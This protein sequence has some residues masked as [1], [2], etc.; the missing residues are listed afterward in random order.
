MDVEYVQEGPTSII[1]DNR[2][3]MALAKNPT[4]HSHNKD[5][6]VEYHLII[7]KLEKK[8]V[9]CLKYRPMEDMIA[10]ML[11]KPLANSRHQTLTK[12]TFDD[13]QSG[14]VEGG[15]LHCL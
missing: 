5:I 2:G 9:I 3:G 11:T 8:Q 15:A 7:R 1:C 13:S 14:S 6:N 4:H 12:A 10:D